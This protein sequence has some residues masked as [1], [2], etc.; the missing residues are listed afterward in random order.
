M[1]NNRK[2]RALA[3]LITLLILAAILLILLFGSVSWKRD[4]ITETTSPELMLEEEEFIE[5]EL[6]ELGEE[7]AVK[8]N[9]P[10]PTLKG[11]PEPAPEDNA[12]IVDPG[13]KPDPNPKPVRNE[14][15]QKKESRLKQE[16]A[17]KT[18]KER[19]KATSSVASK[20]SSKNGSTEGSDK[21][22]SGAGGTGVGVSGNA[23]GRSFISCPKPDVTLRHKTVVTVNVVI[24]AEGKVTEAKASGSASAEIRRKCEAAARQARWSAKKGAT[25]TRGSITFTITPR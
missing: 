9:K 3:A 25:S 8:Q 23:H 14:I 20:F 24:D 22:T 2:D 7:T 18:E 15:T 12:E 1:D 11:E 6:V 13:P 16:E 19:K 10:A 5:P 17:A 21:G 4:A